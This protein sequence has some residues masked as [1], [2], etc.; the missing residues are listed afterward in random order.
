[1]TIQDLVK[2]ALAPTNNAL[3]NE[4]QKQAAAEEMLKQA[5]LEELLKQAALEEMQKQA[6]FEE[7]LKQAAAEE[8][9]KQAMAELIKRAQ[10]EQLTKQAGVLDAIKSLLASAGEKGK[11]G[12]DAIKGLASKGVE[13]AKGTAANAYDN[14]AEFIAAHPDLMRNLE[15]GGIAAGGM[16]A[17]YGINELLQALQ[18]EEQSY[19]LDDILSAIGLNQ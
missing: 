7:L 11:A 12:V 15:R 13:T 16:G 2:Q 9:K 4:M 6:A 10:M 5:A 17:G 1:M 3:I 14:I 8:L 18:P 19:S